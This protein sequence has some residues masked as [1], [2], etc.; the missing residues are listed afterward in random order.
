MNEFAQN[1]S[2]YFDMIDDD[3]AGIIITK[4]AKGKKY[5][6]VE[7]QPFEKK[8]RES[9]YNSIDIDKFCDEPKPNLT[10]VA[11]GSTDWVVRS[12]GVCK[13]LICQS[14]EIS[15]Y[16]KEV[17]NFDP[18]KSPVARER[19]KK[20]QEI[21][22]LYDQNEVLE[23]ELKKALEQADMEKKEKEKIIERL[24]QE[25]I[26]RNAIIDKSECGTFQIP[27]HSNIP[28]SKIEERLGNSAKVNRKAIRRRYFLSSSKKKHK[29]K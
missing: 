1:P 5:D 28:T 13:Y 19:R 3:E 25:I 27:E 20:N 15:I 10:L 8:F 23:K 17:K 24:N 16:I 7:I 12:D 14:E 18:D 6:Y 26:S 4:E 2:A 22:E 11:N 29:A 21:E 9:S